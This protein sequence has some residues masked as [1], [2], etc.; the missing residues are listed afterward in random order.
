LLSL[1]LDLLRQRVGGLVTLSNLAADVQ[2][3]RDK[4]GREVDF[5]ILKENQIDDLVEVKW[6]DENISRSL[7]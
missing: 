7:L 2:I 3:F 5:V 6:A 4:E 1:F